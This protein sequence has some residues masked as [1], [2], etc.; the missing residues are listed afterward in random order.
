MGVLEGGG[1]SRCSLPGVPSSL[2]RS[3]SQLQ[4]TTSTI[5]IKIHMALFDT[6][7]YCSGCCLV[8]AAMSQGLVM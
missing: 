8:A 3:A 5:R 6:I 1:S 2:S 4:G 7:V